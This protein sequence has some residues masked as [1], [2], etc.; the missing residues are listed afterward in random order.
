MLFAEQLMHRRAPVLTGLDIE[1]QRA[2]V[3]RDAADVVDEEAVR[4]EERVGAGHREIAQMLV[5][6][7]VEFIIVDQG[8]DVGTL[9]HG[10]AC[11]L[12]QRRHSG[13]KAV[14]IGD[15]RQ[16]VVRDDEVGLLSLGAQ[17]PGQIETEKGVH[18][19]HARGARRLDGALRRIDT[20]HGNACL[21]EILQHISVIAGDLGD[22]R[23]RPE[24]ARLDQLQRILA[25]MLEEEIR[26]GG[27]VGIVG[28][29]QN[30]RVDRFGDLHKRAVVAEGDLERE[31]RLRLLELL[32]HEH[33]I[34]ERHRAEVEKDFEVLAAARAACAKLSVHRLQLQHDV[35]GCFSRPLPP[36]QDMPA[37]PHPSSGAKGPRRR[38]APR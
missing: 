30:L 11:V 31:V 3:D 5:V 22:Q 33:A 29:E 14:R 10:H 12:Q 18:R 28:V 32:R 23:I 24:L 27:V 36:G 34:R 19:V 26:K 25:R 38:S 6:D 35:P 20:E 37:T 16:H 1:A 21:D 7:R 17:L 8:L 9:D 4:L 15:M 2:A 13:D